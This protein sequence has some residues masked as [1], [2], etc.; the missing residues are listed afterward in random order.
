LIE[1][2]AVVRNKAIAVGAQGWL[3]DLGLLIDSVERDWDLRI[4]RV[5]PDASEALVAETTLHDGSGAVLKLI[6]PREG[7][8]ARHEIT[9][10]QLANGEGCAQLLRSD[11]ARGALLMERLGPSLHDLGLPLAERLEILVEAAAKVWRSAVDAA[12]PTGA[13]KGRWLSEFIAKMWEELDHPCSERAVEHALAC[14]ARRID[15]HD[16]E[17][18]VLVHGDI[19]EWNALQAAD[20]YKLVDPDGLLAEAE[21]D[22]GVLMREDPVELLGGDPLERARWLAA[23]SGLDVT[24]IWEWGVAERVSTGLLCTSVDLQPI[25]RQML[26]AADFV[27]A[28]TDRSKVD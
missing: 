27:A 10:L 12:L 2:P 5:F 16:D 9:V 23:R 20:G 6:V 11:E 24:A 13:E 21:Y 19:H 25:G 18:S 7:D 28:S 22:L 3:D 14:A 17:R 15:A 1:I 8:A 4:S 26:A